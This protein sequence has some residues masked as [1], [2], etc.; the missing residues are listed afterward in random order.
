[1]MLI[2]INELNDIVVQVCNRNIIEYLSDEQVGCECTMQQCGRNQ[3]VAR[4]SLQGGVDH[5]TR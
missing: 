1:M 4:G 2:R 5:N 3:Q